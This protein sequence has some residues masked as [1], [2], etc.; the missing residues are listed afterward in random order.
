MGP[1][2]RAALAVVVGASL[3]FRPDDQA[4]QAQPSGQL[5]RCV[6]SF[7]DGAIGRPSIR[8]D[9]EAWRHDVSPAGL[10][11][12]RGECIAERRCR[13]DQFV[14]DCSEMHPKT[15]IIVHDSIQ[16]FEVGPLVEFEVQQFEEAVVSEH[17][18]QG[19]I[20]ELDT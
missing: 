15:Q 7:F 6:K 20:A 14:V 17:D 5:R 19:R 1:A 2:L 16:E 12:E 13:R 9:D 4:E 10:A 3:C 11:L 18:R 8:F